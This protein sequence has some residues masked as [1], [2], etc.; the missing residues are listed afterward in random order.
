MLEVKSKTKQN[1]NKTK[2]NR[3]TAGPQQPA[4]LFWAEGQSLGP[5]RT[6]QDTTDVFKQKIH[7]QVAKYPCYRKPTLNLNSK[8]K[9]LTQ[10][11]DSGPDGTRGF[12]AFFVIKFKK[13]ENCLLH[14]ELIFI[15][16]TNI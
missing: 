5:L 1:K 12:W 15:V 10:F 9:E 6:P 3:P 8:D 2:Q 11:V 13:G 16:W 4:G 14:K 7:Q